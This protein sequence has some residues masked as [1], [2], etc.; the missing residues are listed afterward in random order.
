MRLTA[1]E[2]TSILLFWVVTIGGCVADNYVKSRTPVN[3]VVVCIN[4]AWT[5]TDRVACLQ[6]SSNAA[7]P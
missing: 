7:N 2:R 6:A 5:V 4:A 1:W 3:P